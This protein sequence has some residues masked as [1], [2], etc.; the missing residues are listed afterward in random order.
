MFFDGVTQQALVR[1]CSLS[2]VQRIVVLPK[3]Y[4]KVAHVENLVKNKMPKL[5]ENQLLVDH[6]KVVHLGVVSHQVVVLVVP[7]VHDLEVNLWVQ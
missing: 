4:G 7:F 3:S 6:V 5:D 1:Y 2:V